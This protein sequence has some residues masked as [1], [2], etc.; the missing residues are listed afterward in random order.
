M[1]LAECASPGHFNNALAWWMHVRNQCHGVS[2]R[3]WP[4]PTEKQEI[5]QAAFLRCKHLKVEQWNA[6]V[7]MF[8]QLKNVI[9]SACLKTGQSILAYRTFFVISLRKWIYLLVKLASF[10]TTHVI[11]NLYDFH[12]WN[13]KRDILKNVRTIFAQIITVNKDAD[14]LVIFLWKS[15]TKKSW[16]SIVN[17]LEM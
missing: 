11:S 16:L 4:S 13:T 8:L 3:I 10:S 14:T 12:L 6:T 5:N 9:I 17:S 2:C 1:L 15:W 7:S